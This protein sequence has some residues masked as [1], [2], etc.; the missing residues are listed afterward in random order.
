[1]IR[2]LVLGLFGAAV[3]ASSATAAASFVTPGRAAYCGVTEGEAPYGLICW[4][5][6]DGF[7]IGMGRRGTASYSYNPRDI[8]YHEIAARRLGFGERW[9]MRGYWKCSSQ[10]WG[11]TCWNL[12]GHGWWLGRHKGY[13]V[14]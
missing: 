1:M 6:N 7:S 8:G 12:D 10:R 5:P 13:R 2:A 14:F 4:T 3:A 11:L 9:R